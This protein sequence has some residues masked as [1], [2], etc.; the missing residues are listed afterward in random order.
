MAHPVLILLARAKA[1][2]QLRA[3]GKGVLESFRL[4]GQVDEDVVSAAV[5]LA[6][7]DVSVKAA[8]FGSIGDGSILKAIMDFLNSDLGKALV[9][10]IISLITAA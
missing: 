5:G 3:Q 10:L 4:A 8:T 6:P 9:A 7:P 2:E 1:R